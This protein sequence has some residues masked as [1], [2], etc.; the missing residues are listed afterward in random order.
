MATSPPGI[1]THALTKFYGKTLGVEDVTF[2]VQ[3]GEVMGFLGPNGSGKTTVMRMLMGLIRVTSGSAEILGRDVRDRSGFPRRSVGY[4]P[5][6]LGLYPNQTVLE[7]LRFMAHMRDIDCDK[8][9]DDLAARLALDVNLRISGLSKGTKQKVGVVQAFMHEPKVLILDEPTSGL[10][11]IV[12]REFETMLEEA[13]DD[14]TAVL[15][16]SHVMHEVEQLAT[17]VAIISKGHLLIVDDVAALKARTS[18]RL[19]LEFDHDVDPS[20]FADVPGVVSVSMNGNGVEC[21][22][23]GAETAVLARAVENSVVAVVSHEPTLEDIFFRETV[24]NHVQ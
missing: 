6:T 19:A 14:G 3:P 2:S 9:I 16:S 24:M 23:V 17:R 13:R 21:V 12:Q 5:G 22:V 1:S 10:D 18:R 15:L 8:A 11:P 4:I 7:Y 20:V